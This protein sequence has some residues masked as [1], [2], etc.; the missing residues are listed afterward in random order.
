MADRNASPD[1]RQVG[2]SFSRAALSYDHVAVLQRHVGDA[3]LGWLSASALRPSRIIDVGAGTGYCTAQLRALY[4]DADLIALDIA[5]GMLKHLQARS[6]PIAGCRL[7]CGDAEVLPLVRGCVDLVFSNLAVQ[8][9]PDLFAALGEFRRVL[10]PGGR[11]IFS[12]FGKQTLYELRTAWAQV[13]DYTHVNEFLSRVSILNALRDSGFDDG[14]V[15]TELRVLEYAAVDALLRELKALGAHNVTRD[16]PRHLT[17]KKVLAALT[18]AY[19]KPWGD[20]RIRASFE[21][22]LAT[23]STPHS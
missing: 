23:A 18:D 19:P 1:K 9:C 5:E 15:R 14:Q 10:R 11:L 2:L 16:R 21:I 6:E 3:L 13:D 17:G 8:W 4:P 7:L 22:V 12:T 20:Q